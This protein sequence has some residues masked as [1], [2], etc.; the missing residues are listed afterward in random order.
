MKK[1]NILFI[2]FLFFCNIYCF[3]NDNHNRLTS[4]TTNPNDSLNRWSLAMGANQS[5]NFPIMHTTPTISIYNHQHTIYF[6]PEFTLLLKKSLG[7]DVD[8]WK[9]KYWG[10]NLGYRYTFPSHWKRTNLF[11][12]MNY[13]I[14]QYEFEEGQMGSGGVIHKGIMVENCAA[15]GLNYRFNNRLSLS[16]G[17]GLGSKAPFFLLLNSAIPHSFVGISYR[18]W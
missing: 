17:I 2:L 9:Q 14:Y 3:G 6:G 15:F 10:F 1:T 12:Q 5:F 16:G 13:S 4:S 8:S 18:I 11:L 7:D